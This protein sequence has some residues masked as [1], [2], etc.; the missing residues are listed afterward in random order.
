M[1]DRIREGLG[2]S[3]ALEEMGLE[4]ID[5]AV[6]AIQ[7][8]PDLEKALQTP[9]LESIQQQ[10]DEAVFRRRA[11]AVEKERAIAEN[12]LAS[13]IELAARTSELIA[14]EGDNQRRKAREESE[15][16]AIRSQAE[17]E[18]SRLAAETASGNL[19][20]EGAA[21]AERIS[22]I[23][24]AKATAE[25][26][27]MEVYGQLQPHVLM[28]LAAREFA[29]KLEKIEH[30]SLAPDRIGQVLADLFQSGS[31]W[32]DRRDAPEMN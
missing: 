30:L 22:A 5:V 32:L 15:A 8:T 24:G 28:G 11:L 4:V 6:S 27:R 26:E 2:S 10:A 14:Q 1:R 13:R 7:P 29:A 18:R 9:T 3:R 23:E 19:R 17:S 12:E 31:Q 16:Q 20:L 21:E 25:R